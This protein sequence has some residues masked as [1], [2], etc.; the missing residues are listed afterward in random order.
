SQE[1]Q[2]ISLQ[3][4]EEV[5]DE[6]SSYSSKLSK[7]SYF[8]KFQIIESILSFKSLENSWDGY[9]AVPTGIKCATNALKIV[10]ALDLGSLEKISDIYPNPNGTITIEWENNY[11]EIVSLEIGKETFTYY[12]EFT[13]FGTK[14]FNKQAITFENT[15]MLK[16]YISA[17]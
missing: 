1:I 10:D 6:I 5:I 14:F 15:K 11:N 17:I 12:V 16:K 2:N 4:T 7:R 3:C 9:N 13:S 8:D